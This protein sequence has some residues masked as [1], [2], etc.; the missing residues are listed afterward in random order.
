MVIWFPLSWQNLECFLR[1]I[2]LKSQR[3]K[4][5]KKWDAKNYRLFHSPFITVTSRL[6]LSISCIIVAN[7]SILPL[8]PLLSR[9]SPLFRR[10]YWRPSDELSNLPSHAH[11]VLLLTSSFV[12]P[13][14]SSP[15]LRAKAPPP[16]SFAQHRCLETE[17]DHHRRCLETKV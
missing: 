16:L 2:L 9:Y 8:L 6:L 5:T 12:P 4:M 11:S 13:T 3:S 1:Q 10:Q 15:A 7:F 14:K 17:S